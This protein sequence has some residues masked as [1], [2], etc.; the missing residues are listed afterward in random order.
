[1]FK[2]NIIKNYNI[3]FIIILI[4]T[5]PISLYADGTYYIAKDEVGVY[6]QTD[7]NGGWYIDPG[8]LRYFK[9]GQEGLYSIGKDK[10][11]KYLIT[12]KKRKFYI[13]ISMKDQLSEEI[14]EY[15][16]K[17]QNPS[18]QKET[19]VIIKGN[20][21]LVP[22]RL[23]YRGKQVEALLLLDTGASIT[24]LY[25]TIADKLN[26]RNTQKALLTVVGGSTIDA[27]IAKLDYVEVG[28]KKRES[29]YTSII[30]YKGS[31]PTHQGLLGMNFLRGLDYKID[32]KK[33]VIRWR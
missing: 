32:F 22:V 4:C 7:N 29:I 1:M 8:D 24:M 25:R 6:F 10:N 13:N 17:H 16:K 30:D 5:W 18:L 9:I 23:A 26:I 31:N 14:E 11:G 20:R 12:D 27:D 19:K 2:K 33:Q 3:I 15:N 21:V 28:P